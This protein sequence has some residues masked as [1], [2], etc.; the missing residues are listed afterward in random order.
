MLEDFMYSVLYIIENSR[1]DYHF[2]ILI[3]SYSKIEVCLCVFLH[4]CEYT[5]KFVG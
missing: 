1:L 5:K 2:E 3:K 4:V